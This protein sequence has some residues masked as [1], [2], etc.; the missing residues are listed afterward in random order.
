MFH[1]NHDVYRHF[2]EPVVGRAVTH[3][4]YV[5][6]S[7]LIN[8]GTSTGTVVSTAT[9]VPKLTALLTVCLTA[10]DKT[11]FHKKIITFAYVSSTS[12]VCR[13]R[14]DA[15]L[16]FSPLALAPGEDCGLNTTTSSKPRRVSPHFVRRHAVVVKDGFHATSLNKYLAVLWPGGWIWYAA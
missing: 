16:L 2:S 3:D 1:I 8:G 11:K 6:G 5:S 14:C 15:S 10:T 9:E 4:D 13:D 12:G 7:W